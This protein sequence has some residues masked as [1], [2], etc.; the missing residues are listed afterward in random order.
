MK[1]RDAIKVSQ[2]VLA[3]LFA[4]FVC[5]ALVPAQSRPEPP[6]PPPPMPGMTI[7]P[8]SMGE[9][10]RPPSLLGRQ[11]PQPPSVL[12]FA[13]NSKEKRLLAVA[14]D[15]LQ[16]HAAF[17]R[18]PDTGAFRLLPFFPRR[19]VVSA[20]S[21]D[22][23]WRAGFSAYASEYSFAKKKH[24]HGVNGW[25]TAR[26]GWV[27]LRLRSGLFSTG[28]MDQS[29]GLLVQLG[30]L[31]LEDVSTSTPGVGE[32]T[33]LV[34]PA[35]EAAKV[36]LYRKLFTGYRVNGFGYASGMVARVNTTYVLRS[37]LNKRVDHLIA[38]R[39]VRLSEEEGVTIV[40]KRLE[41]YP[42]PRWK[43][44]RARK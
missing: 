24:G 3:L 30:D 38:F 4:G 32:L 34:P 2:F 12:E 33:Q 10:Y 29:L 19:K 37:I 11:P 41:E 15:D 39:V 20:N 36:E 43:V 8:P 14:Q 5:A 17:L 7:G 35:N 23:G 44:S 22:I 1:L 26:F 31:P 18:G 21:P 9:W 6:P 40:W 27:E 42:K 13:P 25:G 16:T 28:V